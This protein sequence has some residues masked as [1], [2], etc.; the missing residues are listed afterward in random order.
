MASPAEPRRSTSKK[1]SGLVIYKSKS[2]L[3]KIDQEEKCDENKL[4]KN[5]SISAKELNTIHSQLDLYLL[6]KPIIENEND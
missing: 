4:D 3:S 2:K 1:R 5:H 6:D